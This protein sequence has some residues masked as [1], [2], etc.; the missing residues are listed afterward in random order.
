MSE[1]I[2]LD[3]SVPIYYFTIYFFVIVYMYISEY[4]TYRHS[5]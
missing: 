2:S 4:Y 1:K 5:S 3:S